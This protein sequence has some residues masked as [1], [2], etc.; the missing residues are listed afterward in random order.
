MMT[1]LGLDKPKTARPPS[2]PADTPAK[3]PSDSPSKKP[4]AA[5]PKKPGDTGLPG[6]L[7]PVHIPKDLP[8]IPMPI[9]PGL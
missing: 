3:K 1:R 6:K 2:K 8:D 7:P 5:P 4:A 9:L